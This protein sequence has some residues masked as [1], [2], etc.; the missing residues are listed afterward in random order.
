MKYTDPSGHCGIEASLG[1]AALSELSCGGGGAAAARIAIQLGVDVIGAATVVGMIAG[2]QESVLL[3]PPTRQEVN[4]I[5]LVDPLATDNPWP[6]AIQVPSQQ[7]L[8][9]PLPT[10]N[11]ADYIVFATFL[12]RGSTGRTMANN[13]AKQLEMQEVISQ[14]PA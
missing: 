4:G 8:A 14:D 12:E 7:V 9:D 2:H 13:L 3:G 1:G 5:P 6:K 11:P 10:V